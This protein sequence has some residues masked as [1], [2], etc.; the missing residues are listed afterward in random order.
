VASGAL[1]ALTSYELHHPEPLI[2]PRFFR[3]VPFSG[4][5]LI[6]I[7]SY[8][9]LGG[10]LFL[11]SLY[12]QDVRGLSA[13]AT[14]LHLLP[15]G[16]GLAVCA[17][18]GGRIV[19]RSGTRIPLLVAG[20]AL[21]LSCAALSRLTSMS[22][23]SVETISYAVF[24]I[25]AGMLN[26]AITSTAVSGMPSAQAGVASG[27][28]SASR[29][30]GLS[31]GV[32]LTGSVLNSSLHGPARTDFAGAS[33]TGWWLLAFCGYM[34]LILGVVTTSQRARRGSGADARAAADR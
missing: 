32:A 2:D 9:A 18:V 28:S 4:A 14:G 27:I 15:A 10:F 20:T 30:V 19:A 12:Q 5:I 22:P 7:F 6:A 34:V 24:G 25:G 17:P 13:L 23:V 29:Q 26:A 1:G 21:T 8:A 33:H 31:L 3:S 16:L 11:S